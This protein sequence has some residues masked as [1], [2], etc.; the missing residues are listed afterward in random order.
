MIRSG[1]VLAALGLSSRIVAVGMAAWH[2]D[3]DAPSNAALAW[4]QRHPEALRRGAKSLLDRDPARAQ[5]MLQEALRANPTE[6]HTLIDLA[7]LWRHHDRRERAMRLAGRIG[8]AQARVQERA[9]GHWLERGDLRQ[10]M[11]HWDLALRIQPENSGRLFPVLLRLAQEPAGEAALRASARESPAWWPPFLVYTANNAAQTATLRTLF[12]L[13]RT[14]N[15]PLSNAERNACV[16]RLQR[17]RRWSEAYLT[18]LNT[19]APHELRV[20]GH[21]YDGG[22][23]LS[24]FG[25]GF[26]WQ[27][28]PR[29]DVIVTTGRTYAIGGRKALHLVFR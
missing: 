7:Q 5:V 2:V 21:L 8:Q 29:P 23:E 15:T 22:F 11:A 14:S 20:A 13:R 24:S 16:G 25:Q 18:W 17:E 12:A 6:G 26:D 27:L 3:Q 9:A 1:L 4:Y 28:H 19:L 10:A